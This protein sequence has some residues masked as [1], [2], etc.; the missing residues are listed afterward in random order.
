[1]YFIRKNLIPLKPIV[2]DFA[3]FQNEHYI[4]LKTYFHFIAILFYRTFHPRR[5]GKA[6]NDKLAAIESNNDLNKHQIFIIRLDSCQ[7]TAATV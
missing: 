6:K 1:M 4:L 5:H 3:K 7:L 2:K